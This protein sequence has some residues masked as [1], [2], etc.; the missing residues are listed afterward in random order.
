MAKIV[1]SV[2]FRFPG[3]I[4]EYIPTNSD[5]SLLD[6][7]VIIFRAD[8]SEFP[9]EETHLGQLRTYQGDRWLSEEGSFALKRAARHWHSQLK[10]AYETNKTVL[11]LLPPYEQ[12][13][14]DSGERSYSGTGRNRHTTVMLARINNYEFLPIEVKPTAGVGTGI[15]PAT[16]LGFLTPLWNFLKEHLEYQ[17]MLEGTSFKPP[18]LTRTGN[19]IVGGLLSG[20]GAL[21]LWADIRLP[22]ETFVTEGG[23]WSKVAKQFGH[24]L[25]DLIIETDRVVH[26]ESNVTPTPT[27]ATA[28]E[29]RLQEESQIQGSILSLDNEIETLIAKRRVEQERLIKAGSLRAL[30]FEKGPRL[31]S[32]VRDALTTLGF[33]ADRFK[34]GE[35]EFDAVF[36]SPEGRFIGEVEGRDQKGIAIEKLSQLERN[37][38]EDYTRDE[39]TTY[40]KGVLFGNAERLIPI[41][42]RGGFFTAKVLS[43][44]Q[45]SRISLVRTPDLFEVAKSL[46][47]FPDADFAKK[48]REAIALGEGGIVVFPKP[49]RPSD[50]V[51]FLQTDKSVP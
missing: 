32:A 14:V 49:E 28:S 44:A 38:Q 23:A 31:E 6:A 51:G 39:I 13:Y 43:G 35:H 45:R 9:S 34:E 27:W 24:Q 29:F 41:E 21:V 26:A 19:K 48:C 11:V 47:N 25:L 30:L 15:K 7:D 36:E 22:R 8:I 3:G 16:D 20:K 10:I 33:Q 40:A 1:V 50:D 17:V 5:R 37:I 4:V 42:Q 2:G 18:L 12:V 46:R